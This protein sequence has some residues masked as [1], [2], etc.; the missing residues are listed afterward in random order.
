M[1]LLVHP[2]NWFTALWSFLIFIR[3]IDYRPASPHI[4]FR[5]FR[6]YADFS[7]NSSREGED[8]SCSEEFEELYGITKERT[9]NFWFSNLREAMGRDRWLHVHQEAA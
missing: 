2:V 7:N 9:L 5:A 8:M 6:I 3:S 4:A 1:F